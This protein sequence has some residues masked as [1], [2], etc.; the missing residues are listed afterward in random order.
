[1]NGDYIEA[2][3]ES[4]RRLGEFASSGIDERH[5]QHIDLP[6]SPKQETVLLEE[7][8]FRAIRIQFQRANLC[9]FVAS[10]I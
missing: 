6:L 9:V 2:E 4:L 1:M 5:K 7:A 8:G 10:K 3:D